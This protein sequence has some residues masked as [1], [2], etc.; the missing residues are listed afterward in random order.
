[1]LREDDERGLGAKEL[2]W[3]GASSRQHE[4]A[5]GLA[6]RRPLLTLGGRSTAGTSVEG[7]RKRE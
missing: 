7:D 2:R 4:A 3:C 1:M 6:E 5:E